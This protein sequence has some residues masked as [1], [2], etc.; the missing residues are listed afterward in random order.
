MNSSVPAPPKELIKKAAL[1]ACR[2]LISSADTIINISRSCHHMVDVIGNLQRGLAD[3]A[4]GIEQ[5]RGTAQEQ[6]AS[7]Y[8][9]LYGADGSV[10]QHSMWP[11]RSV[12]RPQSRPVLLAV[13]SAVSAGC[14]SGLPTPPPSTVPLVL[15]A[16]PPFP[17]A[18][19]PA[20]LGSRVKFVVDGPEAIYGCLDGGQYLAA[21]RRFAR[22]VDIH[23]ALSAHPKQIGHRFPLLH[24]QWPL[25][26]KFRGQ[27]RERALEWLG[28]QGSVSTPDAAAALAAVALLQPMV[29]VEVGFWFTGHCFGAGPRG[30]SAAA[31]PA[32]ARILARC[33]PACWLA[34]W[35]SAC[36]AVPP[37]SF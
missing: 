9:R 33:L 23:K 30:G 1:V 19:L 10:V 27:I 14:P 11:R 13:G 17:P 8:D 12:H 16:G 35:L 34:A 32:T 22:C 25:V 24:H 31:A 18:C 7:S 2:D 28:Q 21:A 36:H 4:S 15:G 26:R 20:A 6:A 5:R 29:G 3:V 37:P